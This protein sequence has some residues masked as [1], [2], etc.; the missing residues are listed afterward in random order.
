MS[1]S[2]Q[3]TAISKKHQNLIFFPRCSPHRATS[4]PQPPLK[5]MLPAG[6]GLSAGQDGMGGAALAPN[7]DAVPGV[8]GKPRG[9]SHNCRQGAVAGRRIETLDVSDGFPCVLEAAFGGREVGC[10]GK[11]EMM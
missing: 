10:E 9:Y 6:S 3:T 1:E 5:H 11:G 2:S 4:L 7:R 8:G